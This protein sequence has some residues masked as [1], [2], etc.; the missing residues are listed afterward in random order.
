[1][2]EVKT[3]KDSKILGTK[4]TLIVSRKIYLI[5][6]DKLKYTIILTTEYTLLSEEMSKQNLN[7][8][9]IPWFENESI[10]FTRPQLI[11]HILFSIE[12]TKK[13]LKSA[14]SATI[15]TSHPYP[16]MMAVDEQIYG[17]IKNPGLVGAAPDPSEKNKKCD[18]KQKRNMG[19]LRQVQS[20]E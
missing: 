11:K 12:T 4:Q 13:K 14:K 18:K 16:V 6:W 7:I 2:Q 5:L 20:T 15:L 10:N 3:S 9:F 17:S 19:S 8:L 1:M